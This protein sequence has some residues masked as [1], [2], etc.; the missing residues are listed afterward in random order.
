VFYPF[1]K[2]LILKLLATL[3]KPLLIQGG[4][5]EF[6]NL[7]LDAFNRVGG[8]HMEGLVLTIETLHKV[9]HPNTAANMLG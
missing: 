7:C 3:D 4:A 9:L 5:I 8:L 1:H 2:T 6:L